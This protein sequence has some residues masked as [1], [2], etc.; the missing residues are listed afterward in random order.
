[1]SSDISKGLVEAYKSIYSQEN[2]LYENVGNFIEYLDESGYDVSVLGEDKI[3][4]LFIVCNSDI[5]QLNEGIEKG[6]MS[7]GQLASAL[8]KAKKG[9]SALNLGQQL[10]SA[11]RYVRPAQQAATSAAQTAQ[12]A[13]GLLKNLATGWQRRS[14][15]RAAERTSRSTQPNPVIQNLQQ[16]AGEK[17]SDIASRVVNVGGKTALGLG[18]GGLVDQGL[19]GGVVGK[20]VRDVT[21]T[22]R[23][24]GGAYDALMGRSSQSPQP[25]PAQ[26]PAEKP[27]SLPAGYKMV[28]GKVVKEEVILVKYLLDEGYATNKK[29]ASVIVENMSDNWKKTIL[30]D[31]E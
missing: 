25:A 28:N 16:K 21:R 27:I 18:I 14:A 17:L 22:S 31:A 29:Q 2:S 5:H 4:E 6:L 8:E 20:V 9:A 23:Q 13:P 12:R 10:A 24:A 11:Q 19:L 3:I 26:P 1:M 30:G 7:F 15:A